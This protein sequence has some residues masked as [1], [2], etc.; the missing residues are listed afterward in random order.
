LTQ[1]LGTPQPV[2]PKL[3]NLAEALEAVAL[4]L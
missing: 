1:N 4:K 3:Q 2:V